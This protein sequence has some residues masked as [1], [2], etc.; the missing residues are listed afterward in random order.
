[1]D[2][3]HLAV[4]DQRYAVEAR[5]IE[6]H[7]C[8]GQRVVVPYDDDVGVLE[9]VEG[10]PV[11]LGHRVYDERDVELAGVEQGEQLGVVL[12]LDEMDVHSR[13]GRA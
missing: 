9:H 3:P 5:G 10:G 7:R 6:R 12:G 4:G 2:R 11:A 1:M 8:R 13:A